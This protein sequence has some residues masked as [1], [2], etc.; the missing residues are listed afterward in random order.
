MTIFSIQ[1][2]K[3]ESLHASNYILLFLAFC[4][5]GL[6]GTVEGESLVKRHRSWF[7]DLPDQGKSVVNPAAIGCEGL[8]LAEMAPV[9]SGAL[10]EHC[11]AGHIDR[12][13]PRAMGRVFQKAGCSGFCSG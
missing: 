3:K 1:R 8:H 9:V 2:T 7:L 10:R 5:L 6:V 13:R 11:L 4:N 12:F